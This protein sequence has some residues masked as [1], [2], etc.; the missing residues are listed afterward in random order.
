MAET[1][2][3]AS[4]K[5]PVCKQEVRDQDTILKLAALPIGGKVMHG[6]YVYDGGKLPEHIRTQGY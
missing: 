6:F 5:C 3:P 2:K 4:F 1:I